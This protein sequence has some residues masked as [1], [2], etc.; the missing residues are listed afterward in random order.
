[1]TKELVS[2]T[3]SINEMSETLKLREQQKRRLTA[4]VAHELRTPLTNLQS[5]VE[6]V[7][8]GVWEPSPELFQGYRDEILRLTRLVEQLQE[9]SNLESGQ[10]ELHL[11]PT[12]VAAL[13]EDIRL[14][15]LARFQSKG[16]S[17]TLGTDPKD[18]SMVCDHD[19]IKQCLTNLVSNAL[20]ATP[21]GGTVRL[22][23]RQEAGSIQ[24]S[25]SDTGEGIPAEHLSQ[26]FERFYRVDPSRSQQTG[27]M[28][29]GLAI[30]KTIVGAHG[31]TITAESIEGKGSKFTIC[32]PL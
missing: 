28:G 22:E 3:Q 29:I 13:L 12:P 31:G 17:L 19:R 15:F 7:I 4:D 8:D 23:G 24:L 9:L 20:R 16:V 30:T 18:I 6:A 5:H 21:E 25:V 10:I 2:L 26:L 27:G 1:M 11:E 14:D 32:L